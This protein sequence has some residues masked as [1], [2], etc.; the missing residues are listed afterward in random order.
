LG[1][2][3]SGGFVTTLLS[4]AVRTRPYRNMLSTHSKRKYLTRVHTFMRN[5]KRVHM[6][7]RC[8]IIAAVIMPPY[9]DIAL[10]N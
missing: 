6:E 7:G 4:P 1:I 2:V 3:S 9:L 5:S 8:D 10:T